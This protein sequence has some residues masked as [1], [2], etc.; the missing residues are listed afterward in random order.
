M[1]VFILEV[2]DEDGPGPYAS[3]SFFSLQK[4][5][6][7]SRG[8]R[9]KP[10]P[11]GPPPPSVPPLPTSVP[12]TKKLA[13]V[14]KKALVA[15]Q[16]P[17]PP[18]STPFPL[19]PLPPSRVE[20]SHVSPEFVVSR[21]PTPWPPLAPLAPLN[22]LPSPVMLSQVEDLI[23]TSDMVRELH[24]HHQAP[25]PL[26]TP[27]SPPL[28]GDMEWEVDPYPHLCESSES[29]FVLWVPSHPAPTSGLP[30]EWRTWFGEALC[31]EVTAEALTEYVKTLS[32]TQHAS[33]RDKFVQNRLSALADAVQGWKD[34]V[35]RSWHKSPVPG[36]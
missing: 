1:F 11:P 20:S 24:S 28:F 17:S 16:P 7:R 34:D 6:G 25:S 9:R 32:F 22:P 27:S 12:K 23:T 19:T 4:K 33:I 29:N 13:S 10:S 15:P 2:L 36:T 18:F 35:V 30:L 8:P 14:L 5:S 26:S 3:G 31:N 21:T